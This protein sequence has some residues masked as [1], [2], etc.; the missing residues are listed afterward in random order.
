MKFYKI[1]N[2]TVKDLIEILQKFKPE[3]KVYLSVDEEQNAL[4][5]MVGVVTYNDREVVLLPLNPEDN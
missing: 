4:A 5:D 2:T 3:T 1:E